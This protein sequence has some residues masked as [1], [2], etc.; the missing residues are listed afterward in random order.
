MRLEN[1]DYAP[2]IV[3]PSKFQLS[4][5]RDNP[6]LRGRHL[7]DGSMAWCKFSA[8]TLPHRMDMFPLKRYSHKKPRSHE[9]D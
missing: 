5:N 8:E 3:W 1:A 4:E 6:V 9:G 7:I 2:K